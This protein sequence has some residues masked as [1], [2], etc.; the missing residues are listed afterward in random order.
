MQDFS[1]AVTEFLGR[2]YYG[3]V[4]VDGVPQHRLMGDELFRTPSIRA[5]A[6]TT[7]V[8]M[9]LLDAARKMAKQKH[10]RPNDVVWP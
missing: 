2:S 5:E 9:R 8:K 1:I 3:E 7:T 10:I 6:L 4:L